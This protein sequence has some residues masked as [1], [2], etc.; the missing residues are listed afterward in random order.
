MAD[1]SG[2][3]DPGGYSAVIDELLSS[4]QFTID[5]ER[6]ARVA[7]KVPGLVAALRGGLASIEYPEDHARRFLQSLAQLHRAALRHAQAPAAPPPEPMA[8]AVRD[9]REPSE[10]WFEPT[11]ARASSLME[12]A[13][14]TEP[15]SG[16]ETAPV[17]IGEMARARQ[18]LPVERLQEGVWVDLYLDGAWGRWRLAWASP[19]QLLF[20]FADGSGHYK[21]MT[22]SVLETLNR[23]GA[24]RFVSPERV[25][26]RALDAVAETALRNSTQ[27]VY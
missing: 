3:D 21:S 5:P 4:T 10:L 20:M 11:E 1:Q 14:A 19:Q 13:P 18:P 6:R 27:S 7:K 23:V 24:L 8:S 25:V 15:Q 26:E 9:E 2:S 16:P 12:I 17:P 22:R